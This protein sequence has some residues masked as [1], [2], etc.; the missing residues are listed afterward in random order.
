MEDEEKD[1]LKNQ[2]E[3]QIQNVSDEGVQINNIDY[4]FRLID[5]KKDLANI[6]YWKEKE[7]KMRRNYGYEYGRGDYGRGEYGRRERDSRGR[8]MTGR[9]NYRGDDMIDDMRERYEKYE[10]DRERYGHDEATM[11]SLEYMLMSVEDFMGHL[12]EDANS[13]EE[14]ELI[15]E[16]AQKIAR[17]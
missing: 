5:I 2:I 1:K 16:T 3:E 17:M 14:T 4:L 8:Y 13:Q 7:E 15:K 9:G 12:M 10:G 11:K 6:E